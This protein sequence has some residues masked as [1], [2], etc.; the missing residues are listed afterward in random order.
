MQNGTEY[1][2]S[3]EKEKSIFSN[4][5]DRLKQKQADEVRSRVIRAVSA[6]MLFLTSYVLGGAEFFF[7]TFPLGIA[8]LCATGIYLVPISGGLL[9]G[10]VT[11]KVEVEYVFAYLCVLL[12]RFIISYAPNI[13]AKAQDGAKSGGKDKADFYMAREHG[14][15]IEGQT[16][17]GKN[18]SRV[19]LSIEK[20]FGIKHREKDGENP[21]DG[22]I[23]CENIMFR[24]LCAGVGGFVA[25]LFGLIESDFSYYNLYGAFFLILLCPIAVLLFSGLSDRDA[26]PGGWSN[27]VAVGTAIAAATYASREIELFGMSMQ[28]MLAMLFVLCVSSRRRLPL[29]IMCALICGALFNV[30]YI[31]LLVISSVLLCLI[32]PL[33]KSAGLAAVCAAIV[34]WC[35][36]FG[37][38]SGLVGVLPPMLLSIPVFIVIDKYFDFA[39]PNQAPVSYNASDGIYFAAAVTEKNKSEAVKDKLNSLSDAFSSLS[40]T[41]YR[42]SDRFRR[43]D[44]LGLK[45]ITEDSFSKVCEGCRNRDVCRGADYSKTLEAERCITSGLHTKGYVEL[46]DLPDNFVKC[47]MRIDKVIDDVNASCAEVTERI[48]RSEKIGVFASNYDDIT[49]ILKD[50]L[51]SE[52]DEYECDTEAGGRVYEYLTKIGFDIKGVVVCGK[53]FRRVIIKG[54]SLKDDTDSSKGGEICRR[55]SDIV[56]VRMTGPVFEVGSDGTLMLF[57]SRP[58]FRA[59][60]SHGRIAACQEMPAKDMSEQILLDPFDESENEKADNSCGDTTDAFLTDNLYFYSLLS[61]GMGSGA[62][63]AFNS[64]MSAMFIEKMLSAGNRADI[65]LRMLNNFLRS[66]NSSSG[67]ECSVTVDLMELDLMSGAAS[68]IKSGA[69]PTYILRK[70]TVYK[71]NSRTM[72]IG[73]IENP[74]ARLTKF[75]M[76]Q[77]DL[78]I[79]I[80]DGCCPDSEDCPWLV[81][82]LNEVELPEKTQLSGI[83]GEWT[84]RMRDKILKAARDNNPKGRAPDDISVSV[85][86]VA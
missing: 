27:T 75:D 43:P 73:I 84:D 8:L 25:G 28:P 23:F 2:K 65:T 70:G 30:K 71:V 18:G 17:A 53:R 48:I 78:V 63:A 42:L 60:C 45:K 24:M 7:G 51:E 15:Q 22:R 40:Q 80:S 6:G 72:P 81:D 33:K 49:S 55:I 67:R 54:V 9:L 19:L 41:F 59:I 69:A 47:C 37:S 83:G 38:T 20:F 11:G 74:D 85:V 12:V 44:I 57:G 86:L 68:F 32:S 14:K 52:K 79:M 31:P 77:G 46:K 58:G 50:A 35:Y 3:G 26:V 66:E 13:H 4:L 64:G 16:S 61:D 34:T 21:D 36:Y 10:F 62:Q 76:K 1:K 56:G 82:I 29:G 5:T 39:Y